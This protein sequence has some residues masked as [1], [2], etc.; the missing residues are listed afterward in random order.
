M[1]AL[2]NPLFSEIIA[3]DDA[4]YKA[5]FSGDLPAL[6]TLLGDALL[7]THSSANTDTKDQY[8]DSLRSGRVIYRSARRTD[9]M[10]SESGG[11][12]VMA[13]NI[14]IDATVDGVDR[15]LNNRFL[16]VWVQRDQQWKLLAWAST[17]MPKP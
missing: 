5:M 13:G 10:L 11:V 3:A 6:A 12:V 8:I 4:R 9:E 7:Y 14:L 15:L 1:N 2:E 16:T 17:P